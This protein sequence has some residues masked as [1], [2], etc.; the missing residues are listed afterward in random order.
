MVSCLRQREL[1]VRRT[2]L[3]EVS[4][5]QY[6]RPANQ[7]NGKELSLGAKVIAAGPLR[8]AVHSGL[9][10]AITTSS[11]ARFKGSD[12]AVKAVR[13]CRP[14]SPRTATN[15]SDAPSRTLGAFQ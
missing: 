11:T 6:Q 12:A 5:R 4:F 15:R 2:R 7:G 13:V 8:V 3:Y 14:R 1:G 9:M 10:E